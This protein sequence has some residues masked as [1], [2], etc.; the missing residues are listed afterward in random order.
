MRLEAV[1]FDF[2][3]TI[4]DTESSELTAWLEEYERHGVPF[5]RAGW[6]AA[7]GGSGGAVDP[8]VALAEAAGAGFDRAAVRARQRRRWLELV[9]EAELLAGVEQRLDE[10]AELGLRL[11]VA[12]S[13]GR[14]WVEPHLDRLGL[15]DRFEVVCSR[16]DVAA[17]KPDP[18]LY[19]LACARL[20]VEPGAA[21]AI[22]DSANGVRAANAA[23]LF[24]VA[25]PNP[26]TA[27]QD[28]A[29]ADLQ[30]AALTELSLRELAARP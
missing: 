5:D 13:S 29:H 30:V 3:G 24:T 25:V 1:V 8:T 4:L 22:E 9:G 7:I 27:D 12:S 6:L 19:L 20:G 16:D 26:V 18:E 2:D 23:G 28:H 21:V 14:R 17:V 10:A 15:L 11:A